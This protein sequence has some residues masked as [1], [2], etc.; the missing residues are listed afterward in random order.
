MTSSSQFGVA[1]R[2]AKAKAYAKD[3]FTP[4]QRKFVAEYLKDLNRKQAAIRA[5]YSEKN[6][7]VI[8]TRLMKETHIK[9]EVDAELAKRQKSTADIQAMIIDRLTK[10]VAA[11]PT[12]LYQWKK[13]KLTITD[14]DEIDDALI[15]LIEGAEEAV[16]RSGERLLKVKTKDQTRAADLLSKLIGMQIDRTAAVLPDGSAAPPTQIVVNFTEGNG[17]R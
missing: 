3:P 8:A 14:S 1:G 16:T 10:I 9:A 5:G 12:D 4:Q 6:A 13:G 15:P 17:E 11:D 7:H 2:K